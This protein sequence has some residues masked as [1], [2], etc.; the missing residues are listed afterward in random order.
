MALDVVNDHFLKDEKANVESVFTVS[1]FS[2]NGQGQSAGLAFVKLKDWA[3]RGGAEN[4]AAAIAGRSMGTFAKYRD[5]MIFALVPPAVPELG[6]ATGFDLWL[7]DETNM[8]QERL[9]AARNQLLRSEEHTSE[10][11]SL[12]RIS[13]AV[14]CL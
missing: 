9:L 4:K 5:A 7:V 2:F 1:G 12:M 3:E 14:F 11:Q 6:N 10:L 13:Y 8:G